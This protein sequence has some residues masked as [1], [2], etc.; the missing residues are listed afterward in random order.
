MQDST[1]S[2]DGCDQPTGVTG[3]AL[4]WCRRHYRYVRK[5]GTPTPHQATCELC[6]GPMPQDGRIRRFCSKPCVDK[7]WKLNNPERAAAGVARWQ[8]DHP[9]RVRV[10]KRRSQARH[11]DTRN[12]RARAITAADYASLGYSKNHRRALELYG[13]E[14]VRQRTRRR[15][16]KSRYNIT[17]EQYGQMLTEQDGTCAICRRPPREDEVLVVDHDHGCCPGR[18]SCG[19]CV[20]GLLCGICNRDLG[21]VENAQWLAAARAYVAQRSQPSLLPLATDERRVRPCARCGVEISDEACTGR[22]R[23]Y[24]EPCRPAAQR[25]HARIRDRQKRAAQ[26]VQTGDGDAQAGTRSA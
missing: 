10:T 17:T 19:A 9:D 11:R 4:G 6:A 23:K 15:S 1:C 18:V 25:E 5:Y 26:A 12:A 8:A 21:A 2:I 14:T 7:A 13:V 20:R 3:A 24:C 16:L 22:P